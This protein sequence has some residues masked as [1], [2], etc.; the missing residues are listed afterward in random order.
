MINYVVGDATKPVGEGV[1][2]ITHICNDKGGWGAG[3]VLA[4]SNSYPQA[5]QVYRESEEYELGTVQLVRV[6]TDLFVCNMIAQKG[7]ISKDNPHPIQYDALQECI[8]K[9]FSLLSDYTSLH[10]P[11]IGCGLAG[12]KWEKVEEIIEKV[13]LKKPNVQIYVYDLK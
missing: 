6:A 2:V 11:R 3:F 1:K 8:T 12:G 4:L 13:H 5:E 9:L 10:M 7:T